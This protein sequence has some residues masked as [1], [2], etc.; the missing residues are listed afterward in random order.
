[1]RKLVFLY[2]LLFSFVAQEAPASQICLGSFSAEAVEEV[3]QIKKAENLLHHE[4]VRVHRQVGSGLSK[5]DYTTL[6]Q[7]QLTLSIQTNHFAYSVRK[8]LYHMQFLI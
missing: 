8:H 3:E 5:A 6:T 4:R 7:Y 2:F 1:M